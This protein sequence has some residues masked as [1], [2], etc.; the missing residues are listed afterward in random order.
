MDPI[1]VLLVED[2]QDIVDLLQ[3]ALEPEFEMPARQQWTGR[4]ATCPQ[5]RARPCGLGTS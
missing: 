5:G 3:M 4:A 2:D 1:R